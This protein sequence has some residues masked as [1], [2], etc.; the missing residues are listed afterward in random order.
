MTSE[1]FQSTVIEQL[2]DIATHM[3]SVASRL[4]DMERRLEDSSV[5]RRELRKDVHALTVLVQTLI[6]LPGRVEVLERWKN[7]AERVGAGQTGFF[8]G[9]RWGML[10]GAGG[11]G[12]ALVKLLEHVPWVAR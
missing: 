11:A 3:G 1:N 9:I 5:D 7:E 4:D 6:G 12:G 8:G 2:R 10:L